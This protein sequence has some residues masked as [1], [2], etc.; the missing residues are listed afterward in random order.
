MDVKIDD[1][2]TNAPLKF[3]FSGNPVDSDTQAPTNEVREGVN[4]GLFYMVVTFA[5]LGNKVPN[6]L[7]DSTGAEPAVPATGTFTDTSHATAEYCTAVGGRFDEPYVCVRPCASFSGSASWAA[8]SVDA[9]TAC[10]G[11]EMT[12]CTEAVCAPGFHSFDPTNEAKP[13][14]ACTHTTRPDL[15][16]GD[17]VLTDQ[18]ECWDDY[19][20]IMGGFPT[21]PD[22]Y[23]TAIM[24]RAP[25]V[26]EVIECHYQ[27]TCS[28]NGVCLDTSDPLNP[29]D[30][31]YRCDCNIGWLDWKRPSHPN[32]HCDFKVPSMICPQVFSIADASVGLSFPFPHR[33]TDFSNSK[34]K[35]DALI[36]RSDGKPWYVNDQDADGNFIRQEPIDAG[37]RVRLTYRATG[38]VETGTCRDIETGLDVQG[39]PNEDEASCLA[40]DSTNIFTAQSAGDDNSLIAECT[41]LVAALKV[42]SSDMA[43]SSGR[44]EHFGHPAESSL[45]GMTGEECAAAGVAPS[46]CV[47]AN[48]V[49]VEGDVGH[50]AKCSAAGSSNLFIP[51][52]VRETVFTPE[53]PMVPSKCMDSQVPPA[54][55]DGVGDTEAEC[56]AQSSKNVF[57]AAVP[58]KESICAVVTKA[59]FAYNYDMNNAG[60]GPVDTSAANALEIRRGNAAVQFETSGTLGLDDLGKSLSA[61]SWVHRLATEQPIPADFVGGSD[62]E[63]GMMHGA[64]HDKCLS[65]GAEYEREV[66]FIPAAPGSPPSCTDDGSPVTSLSEVTY[67]ACI[68]NKASNV[69]IAEVPMVPS[70]C[71][72]SRCPTPSADAS[73][74]PCENLPDG[75]AWSPPLEAVVGS[76]LNTLGLVGRPTRLG[77][78]TITLWVYDTPKDQPGEPKVSG[79]PGKTKANLAAFEFS[80]VECMRASTCSTHGSCVDTSVPPSVYDG[81]FEC[82]CDTGA[83]DDDRGYWTVRDAIPERFCSERKAD[84]R[85]IMNCPA[86]V[87]VTIAAAGVGVDP[88]V[89][90]ADFSSTSVYSSRTREHNTRPEDQQTTENFLTQDDYTV[91]LTDRATDALVPMKPTLVRSDG[92]A[93]MAKYDPGAIVT[94]T[95]EAENHGLKAMCTTTITVLTVVAGELPW[96]VLDFRYLE[97]PAN[98]VI[99]GASV[100]GSLVWSANGSLPK[101]LKPELTAAV[102]SV[103]SF[104]GVTG[105]TAVECSMSRCM[106]SFGAEVFGTDGSEASCKA[107]GSSNSVYARLHPRTHA[108]LNF[109]SPLINSYPFPSSRTSIACVSY[110]YLLICGCL[111]KAPPRGSVC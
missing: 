26:I 7:T 96:G 28:G 35:T 74:T 97:P 92:K 9:C 52:T 98:V 87:S 83:L 38:V 33:D 79:N 18:E 100:S 43:D 73:Q 86:D 95:Y 93:L 69:F 37:E 55:V 75:V 1:L 78:Y 27:T 62:A 103:W 60:Y 84:V 63:T 104:G 5:E 22:L 88:P 109:L 102:D 20:S 16:E 15:P 50:S 58:M 11:P 72:V 49:R 8:R 10:T 111:L 90:S 48:G 61:T 106:T 14:H 57:T 110:C 36:T 30:G 17:A 54:A 32:T 12:D 70:R 44:R 53:V 34:P 13:C 77:D 108:V 46:M 71:I 64:E 2:A 76:T 66:S 85:P 82:A 3:E 29:Y 80:V 99:E 39:L 107:A 68:Q 21:V 19:Y 105:G 31:K 41:S 94:I 42:V 101:G 51:A 6:K 59:A 24:N 91:G 65:Y 25:M 47:N 81:T 45:R 89:S 4:A 40:E 67:A 56:L 23:G